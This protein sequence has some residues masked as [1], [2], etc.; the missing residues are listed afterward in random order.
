MAV[1]KVSKELLEIFEFEKFL[2]DNN[3]LFTKLVP[4]RADEE[5]YMVD[6]PDIPKGDALITFTVHTGNNGETELAEI[7]LL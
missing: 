2:R 4:E 1:I 5:R 3:F 6:R 7:I